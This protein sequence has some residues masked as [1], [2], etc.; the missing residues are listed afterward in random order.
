MNYKL[1]NIA[2]DIDIQRFPFDEAL[3]KKLNSN[4]FASNQWP[5][6]YIL[7]DNKKIMYI[8]E[9]TNLIN[10]I[11]SHLKNVHKKFLKDAV[12]IYSDKFNKSAALHLESKL[13]SYISADGKFTLLNA[14]AGIANHNYFEKEKYEKVFEHVWEKLKELDLVK[15]S[16]EDIFNSDVF[17]FSPYKSLNNDQGVTISQIIEYLGTNEKGSVFVSGCAGTGKTILAIFLIKLLTTKPSS[18]E[19]DDMNALNIHDY[20]KVVGNIQKKYPKIA[21]VVPMASLRSTLKKV[22]GKIYGLN[23]KMVISPTDAAKEEFDILIVDEAHRL[24]QRKNI[25]NYKSYDDTNRRLGL[26]KEATELD[27]LKLK[28]KH[29]IFFY[30]PNQSIKPS[31]I[32]NDEFDIIKQKEETLEL[33]LKSQI[34]SKGGDSYQSFVHRL[35][36]CQLLEEDGFESSEFELKLFDNIQEMQQAIKSKNNEVGLSRIVAGYSWSWDKKNLHNPTIEID[37]YKM[38][39]NKT[40]EDWINSETAEHEVGCIHTT[41]GYDLN[42]VG[43][44]FGNEIGYDPTKK[45]ITIDKDNYKDRN[46]KAGVEDEEK[47]KQFIINIYKTLMLRGIKGV[48]IYCCDE[49]LRNYFNNY[50]KDKNNE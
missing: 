1:E 32:H 30:D 9:S 44:I 11:D 18:I 22:F 27:W 19:T 15:H 49:N 2:N 46:G 39:W 8:G 14:N 26:S 28:S 24:K 16:H 40:S 50:T 34:R 12:L 48:Y 20:R 4:Y 23:S 3:T 38:V 17:K 25:T 10:R 21:L 42:Y 37:G 45:E 31:D 6:V 13:I 35:L 43:V 29:Q 33:Q 47:L 36:D 41:Q 7:F 5:T